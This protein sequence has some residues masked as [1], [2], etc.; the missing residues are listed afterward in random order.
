MR[1]LAQIEIGKK[2]HLFAVDMPDERESWM[3]HLR[4]FCVI[5]GK[6]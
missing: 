4:K 1:W 5:G 2:K 3:H 6:S